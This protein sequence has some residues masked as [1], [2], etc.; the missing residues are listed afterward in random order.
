MLNCN[1]RNMHTYTKNG[2]IVESRWL[3]LLRGRALYDPQVLHIT[4]AEHDVSVDFVGGRNIVVGVVISVF[5]AKGCDI[6]EC[7]S[8]LVRV[9]GVQNTLI[10]SF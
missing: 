8:G 3:V 6:L 5:G 7:D 9:D 10:S 2:R 4:T 1:P